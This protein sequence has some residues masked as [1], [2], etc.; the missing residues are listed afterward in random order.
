MPIR[1][2]ALDDRDFADLVDEL[3]DRVSAHTP[4][5]S[6]RLGDPGRTLIELFAWLADTVLYRA[7]LIPER[8]RLAFLRLLGIGL[9]PAIAATGLVSV[10]W[11]EAI[12]QTATLQPYATLKGPV[13]FETQG[14][15]TVLPVTAQG[16][17]KRT[18][19]AAEAAPFNDELEAALIQVYGVAATKATPYM[20]TP[21]FAE[22]HPDPFDLMAQAIDHCL[23][24]A[25]LA[26]LPELVDDVRDRLGRTDDGQSPLLNVGVVPLIEM[27]DRFFGEGALE[28]GPRARLPYVWEISSGREINGQPTYLPLREVA[29]TTA[30]LTQPGV[31]RLA[32]PAPVF[33]GAL[34][35]DVQT[36]PQAGTGDRPPRIDDPDTA[37]RLVA[38]IRLRPTAPLSHFELSW[39]GINAVEIDQ[40]QTLRSRVIGIS[41]GSTGQEF[42][43][44]GQ[45]VDPATLIVEVNEPGQDYRPWQPIEDLALAGRDAKVYQLDGEAGIVRFG[46]GLR[47]QIPPVG[48][49]LRVALMRAGGGLAGNLPAGSLTDIAAQDLRGNSITRLKVQQALPTQGGADAED[50]TSA[51]QR[52][53][54]LLRHCDRAVTPSDYR[55][56]AADTPG[57]RVGRV[58]VL[59]R[60]HPHRVPLEGLGPAEEIPGVVSVMVLPFKGAQTPPNPRPD[61]PFLE[62]I[63]AYL[64]SRRPLGTEL[65]VIG[66]KYRPLGLSVGL[67]LLDG[68]D[69]D[70]VLLNVREA[71]F[72]FLWPLISGDITGTGWRLGKPIR[73]RELEV[74]VARVEG[75]AGVDQVKLF[76]QAQDG[77]WTL[78]TNPSQPTAVEIALASWELPELLAVVVAEGNAPNDLI[79]AG[80]ALETDSGIGVP[81]VL[82]VC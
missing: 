7:N 43:L 72:Q 57:V 15:L 21:V 62:T 18:L 40:R 6:P 31:L 66:C 27:P 41:D 55:R 30:G 5:W 10:H 70:R 32:L 37:A 56:L 20:T 65:Y 48:Q 3:L 51:E 59:P 25:L 1:P 14:E 64:E 74:V 71:L 76:S 50:L 68:F 82:E 36:M 17:Y 81:V 77:N 80:P 2:P 33:M 12:A 61:R 67:E 4:E 22:G 24:L 26:P 39:V 19:T 53:P 23:W 16:F 45:S 52:I 9:R 44:P 47:G 58:E 42:A 8:Q 60:F 28:I 69:R 11:N 29:D 49:R 75:V 73:D 46:D 54:A 35:N 79:G 63:H 38:W 13:P 78:V 34:S